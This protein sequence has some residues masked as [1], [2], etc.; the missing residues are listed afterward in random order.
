MKFY[1]NTKEQHKVSRKVKTS[2]K[3]RL[4]RKDFATEQ[5]YMTALNKAL[6]NYVK[7]L[8]ANGKLK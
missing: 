5:E 7:W 2:Q 1:L 6:K 3:K 4:Y 8:K